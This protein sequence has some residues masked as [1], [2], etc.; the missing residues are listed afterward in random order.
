M[1]LLVALLLV[2]AVFAAKMSLRFGI[3]VLVVFIGIGFIAGSDVLNLIYFDDA[4]LTKKIADLI[5][6]FILFDGGFRTSRSELRSVAGPALSLATV[7]VAL[8]ALALGFFVH[9]ALGLDFVRALMISA[10]ISSTDAAAVM[11]ITRRNPIAGKAAATLNVESAANDPMAIL[12]TLAFVESLSGGGSGP[13]A[14]TLALVWQLAGGIA[15][16]ALMSRVAAWLFD[17]LGSES[18]GY[19]DVLAVGL[20]LLAYALSG[21]ARANGVIA[22]FFMGYWLGNAEFA[23]KRGVGNFLES[24][25]AFGNIALFLMLG[26]LAFPSRFVLIAGEALTVAVLLIFVARPLAVLAC[27]LPF[28]Y[29]ARERLLIMW[30]GVKGAV[31]IVLATY[32]AA[33]GLDPEGEVFSVIFFAVLASCLFQGTSLGALARRLGLAMPAKPRSLHTLELHSLGRSDYGM[34]EIPVEVD[35]A[36]C[37]R[38]IAELG[39]DHDIL[40]SSIVRRD[41]LIAPR[42]DTR[43]EA[44]DLLFVLAPRG[45]DADIAKALGAP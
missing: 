28:R 39:L 15:V 42:G 9:L 21:L 6:I 31:P 14:F 20:I 38:C 3:P 24:L 7:G 1:I 22:V 10:I 25:S 4:A 36:A 32:P 29:T 37:G 2:A 34:L 40:I 27:T 41:R 45:R 26:L 5:L 18:R 16:G 43:I 35:F 44:G 23:G 19:Y 11:S 33:Y 8:T 13:L 17:R 30:G 12:L